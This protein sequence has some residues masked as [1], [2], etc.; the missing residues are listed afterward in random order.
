[1]I[2]VGVICL[3]LL[4]GG[5]LVLN[6]ET[7]LLGMRMSEQPLTLPA[8]MAFFALLAG[9]SDPAR[10]LA[11][12]FNQLQRGLAAADRVFAMMDRE[13]TIVSP[14]EPRPFPHH[15]RDLAFNNVSFH[16]HPEQ[17]VLKH[18]S[19][20][21]MRNETLA[22]VGP[23]G[24]GKSTLSKLIPRF[25]DPVSGN[26]EIGGIDLRDL[27]L[28]QLRQRIGMVNQN[29]WLFDQTI[30]ENIRYGSPHASD[31]EVI[32]AARRAH[33]HSF[34]E[35]LLDDGYQTIAGQG[36]QL[37]SGGQR[38]RISLARAILRDPEILIL[39][40]A[41]SQ[42]DLESEKLIHAALVD[43]I[44]D[45]TTFVITHRL[46]TLELADR[47]AVIEGGHVIDVGT[48]EQLLGRCPFYSRLHQIDLQESA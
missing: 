44:R 29:T 16:Y 28:R 35:Q 24:C 7:H 9:V 45:R 20:R 36:G 39:D 19:L 47:I 4:A 41:T 21:I 42:I 23:N 25:Y 13:P 17:P 5:Y 31:A 8:L 3:A 43:F 40:E 48:H 12:I 46:S 34:I 37:L 6:G 18:V 14:A 11:E 30:M 2:G 1:M 10:K 33:A 15:Y 38:Q 26:I 27:H 32:A 22:I